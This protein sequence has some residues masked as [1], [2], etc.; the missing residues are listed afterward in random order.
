[1]LPILQ[2]KKQSNLPGFPL[3]ANIRSQ[4]PSCEAWCCQGGS[5]AGNETEGDP[6]ALPHLIP[7]ILEKR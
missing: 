6:V 5:M 1:M 7:E 3:L 4:A 2:I